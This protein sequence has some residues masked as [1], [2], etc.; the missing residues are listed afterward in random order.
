[1]KIEHA[2][3]QVQDPVGAAEW[4][5]KH[6]G[7]TVKRSSNEGTRVHFLADDG[8]AVMIEFY[9]HPKVAVPDYRSIDPFV[10]HLAFRA[11]DLDGTRARLIAAGATPEGDVLVMDNGDRLA[12]LRDPWGFPLQ[13]AWRVTAMIPV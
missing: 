11:E 2:A 9:N 6:L 5:G 12:M 7:M 4:Y 1:M 10:M 13:L 8:E 3:Y